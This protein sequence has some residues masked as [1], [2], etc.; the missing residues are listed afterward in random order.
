MLILK[1]KKKANVKTAEK[2]SSCHR[3][4]LPFLVNENCDNLLRE[5]QRDL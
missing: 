2:S 1:K 3:D 5:R 4:S